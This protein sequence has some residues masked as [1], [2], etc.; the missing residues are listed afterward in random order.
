[1]SKDD[2]FGKG[3][4]DELESLSNGGEKK[5]K[6][7][8]SADEVENL[9]KSTLSE[10]G[11]DADKLRASV[12]A[13]EA[14]KKK[15]KEEIS[16]LDSILEPVRKPLPEPVHE[17]VRETVRETAHGTVHDVLRETVHEQFIEPPREREP[18]PIRPPER[19]EIFEKPK[20]TEK[21]IF[22]PLPEKKPAAARPEPSLQRERFEAPRKKPDAVLFESYADKPK[23][24][25]P[26]AVV[27]L[28]AVV[29]IGGGTAA[30]MLLKSG[31][32]AAPADSSLVSQPASQPSGTVTEPSL[33]Q[34]PATSDAGQP[35]VKQSAD[36]GAKPGVTAQ[37]NANT[38]AAPA[39][40]QATPTGNQQA[41][42]AQPAP[43]E[44]FQPLVPTQTPRV[45][46]VKPAATQANPAAGTANPGT[47]AVPPADNQPKKAKAG[48]L[49]PLEQVD[50]Q[51]AVTSKVEAS[52]PSM[53]QRMGIEG[54]VI[55]NALVSESGD[56]IRTAILRKS[57]SG[58]NYGFETASEQAVRQWKFKPAIKDGVSVKTWK[59]VAIVFKK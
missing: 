24:K 50:V 22:P 8:S 33:G 27:I 25:F 59:P 13:M 16:R 55:V 14:E 21:D 10:V 39:E 34:N 46:D 7:G 35:A 43:A 37:K 54:T 57:S 6:K 17:P 11:I 29:V 41:A 47:A 40:K 32:T 30:F 5:T 31:K 45:Q 15:E 23:K 1:M 12:K 38:P 19:V 28:A 56:V 2:K 44:T 48:D 49:I 3:F 9:L 42:E 58:T 51:P 4:L 18:R 26:V 36:L 52:Y 53:A 20:P